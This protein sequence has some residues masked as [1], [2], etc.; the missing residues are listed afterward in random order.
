ML[1]RGGMWW[2]NLGFRKIPLLPGWPRPFSNNG[3]S[4]LIQAFTDNQKR[5]PHICVLRLGIRYEAKKKACECSSCE[6]MGVPFTHQAL[7]KV[8]S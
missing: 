4:S 5:L 1:G 3:A 2:S 8:L 6:P 7:G